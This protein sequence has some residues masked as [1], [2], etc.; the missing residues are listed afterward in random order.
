MTNAFAAISGIPSKLAH[1]ITCLFYVCMPICDTA[2]GYTQ[3]V[4]V[5]IEILT[6]NR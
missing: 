2:S 6:R 1:G 5:D 4:A 3:Q